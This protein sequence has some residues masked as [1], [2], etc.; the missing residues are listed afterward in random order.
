V[1]TGWRHA[2][3]VEITKGL[4][5]GERIAV[6]GNFLIDSESKLSL[7]ASGMQALLVK[8]P[9]CGQEVSSRKA[10]KEWLK[11]GHGGKTYYFHSEECKQEFQKDPERFAE[12]PGPGNPPPQPTS[13]SQSLEHKGHVHK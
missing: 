11:T 8:D 6:S 5:P 1:E 10:E 3:Q 12:N 2:N 9:A 13:P 7:A 4:E